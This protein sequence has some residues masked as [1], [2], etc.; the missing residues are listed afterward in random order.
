MEIDNPHDGYFKKLFED[1]EQARSFFLNYLPDP[2]KA[3]I[4]LT[5]IELEKESFVDEQLKKFFSDLI[6]KIKIKGK[7]S[8]LYI[9]IDHKSSPDHLIAFN[10]ARYVIKIWEREIKKKSKLPAVIPCV[11][12][13]GKDQWKVGLRLADL[14]EDSPSPLNKYML[15]FEYLLIDIARLSDESIKGTSKLVLGLRILKHI[16]DNPDELEQ[17]L[18]QNGDL[19][20][21]IWQD[22]HGKEFLETFLRYLFTTE[23]EPDT[24]RKVFINN[25]SPSGGDF[26]M[27]TAEKLIKQ[28][29]EQG[30]EKGIEQGLEKGKKERNSEIA[31]NMLK[32]NIDKEII[33][34]VTGLSLEEIKKIKLDK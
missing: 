8:Y 18:N 9:L 14:C 11:F 2:V 33:I 24:T 27:S 10:L 4:D 32:E 21:E 12:Y 7:P 16:F 3:H 34:K 1:K 13:H 19:L 28:G 25:I 20:R 5:F 15:D 26:V 22:E 23:I 17:I 31:R 6:Y 29:I 30:L